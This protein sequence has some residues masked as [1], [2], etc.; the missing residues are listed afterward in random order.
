LAHSGFKRVKIV[1]EFLKGIEFLI[2]VYSKYWERAMTGIRRIRVEL[3]DNTLFY[4]F[5]NLDNAEFSVVLRDWIFTNDREDFSIKSLIQYIKNLNMPGVEAFTT[6]LYSTRQTIKESK[7]INRL[8]G[9]IG[10][11][12][13]EA[14]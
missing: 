7:E 3:W 2:Y 12:S 1:N 5:S 9:A 6:S 14:I 4:I 13:F 11:S 10:F 8:P